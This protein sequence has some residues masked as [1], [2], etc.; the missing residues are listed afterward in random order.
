MLKK[1]DEVEFREM[2]IVETGLFSAW[3]FTVSGPR[4]ADIKNEFQTRALNHPSP[5]HGTSLCIAEEA[6]RGFTWQLCL[7]TPTGAGRI[8]CYPFSVA[9][10]S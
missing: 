4:I 1:E 5:P 8:E 6:F 2:C 9:E 7:V 10:F 3:K